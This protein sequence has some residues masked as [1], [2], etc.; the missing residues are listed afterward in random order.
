MLRLQEEALPELPE[1]QAVVDSLQPATRGRQIERVRVF[2]DDF[3]EPAGAPW[4]L[5]A[6]RDIVAVRRRAKRIVFD[7]EGGLSFFAHLG[8]TGRFSIERPAVPM[9]KH[10]HVCIELD[11]G[12]QLRQSDPRRFGGIVWCGGDAEGDLGPEPLDLRAR[13]LA[14]RLLRT[15]RPV[16]SALLDQKFI[17]GLGNIYVDEAL[18][19]AG[20]HPLVACASID[21]AS[22]GR[23]S[24]SI[25]TTLR[26]ALRHGGS[27]LRDYVDANGERGSFQQQHR[28]Y[29]REGQC[30]KKCRGTIKRIVLNQRSTHFCPRC[31]P[32]VVQP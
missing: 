32:E 27:T 7:L 26:K 3:A 25:K 31:Q 10:T 6:G 11:N 5:A 22:A 20:I 23:L 30:C 2:R 15:R 18:H 8:M 19:T 21:R 9:V 12:M 29:G 16:K 14:D 4:H 28:V 13:Q 24:R 1:V 17:A